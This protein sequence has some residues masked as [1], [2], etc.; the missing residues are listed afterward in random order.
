MGRIN[1]G[2]FGALKLSS[3]FITDMLFVILCYIGPHHEK[4]QLYDLQQ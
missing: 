1:M 4:T 3:A 2:Y